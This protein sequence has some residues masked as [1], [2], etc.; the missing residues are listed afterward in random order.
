MA[1]GE[2]VE[3]TTSEVGSKKNTN[4]EIKVD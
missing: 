1:G 4:D 2:G 3:R